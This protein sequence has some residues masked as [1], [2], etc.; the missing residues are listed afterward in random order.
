MPDNTTLNTGTGGDVIATDEVT[1]LNGSA[2]SGVKV[3]RVKVMFGAD[4]A[5]TDASADSPLP[6]KASNFAATFREPFQSFPGSN[7][8]S[9]NTVSGDVVR[10][11]GNA[12]GASYLTISKNPLDASGGDTVIETV[13]NFGMPLEV[14]AGIHLSQRINGQEFSLELTSNET[15]DTAPAEL[16][17]SSISQATTT[18]TV[19]TSASHG[20]VVGQRIGIYG[21]SDSRMN[22][23]TLVVATTPSETQFTCTAGPQGALPSVTAGPF[24][25]GFVYS[26]SAMDRRPNGTS[27]IFENAT[28]TNASFYTKSENGDPMPI[29]GTLAGSHAVTIASTASVQSIN[30]TANYAFRPTSEYRLVQ[31]ADRVQWHDVAIDAV[32]QSTARAT[33]TQVIP[34]NAINYKVRFRARN[35]KGLTVPNAKIVSATKTGTTTA[36]IVTAAAHGLTTGDVVNIYGIRDQAAASFPNLTA[37]TAVASVVDA[38][39]FT[40][41]IGTAS[42]VT[43]YGGYVSRVQG[44]QVQ[45]GAITQAVQS[46]QITSSRLTLV[47]SANWT[48]LSIGDFVNLHGCRDNS[49]GADLTIDGAFRVRD[50]ATTNLVLEPLPGTTIPT[51]LALT[52]CGGGIIKRTDMR[53]SFVRVF[54][55]DRLRIETL[56]R[57]TGDAAGAAPTVVQGGTIAISSGTVTT[58]TTLST[59]T[60]GGAAEDA[61][62]GAN[63]VTVGG[64]V[65]T[66][67]TPTTLVAGD[68]IR[69]TFGATGA[70]VVKPYAVTEAEWNYTG[71]LTTT[72]AVPAVAAAGAS[73]RR[74]ITGIQAINTGASA[75]DLIILDGAVERW[76][77]TLPPN[78]PIDPQFVNALTA[79]AN[80]ALNLNLSAAGT[81][82][83]NAQG[84]TA[85]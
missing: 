34:N 59:L 74:Y 15:Q 49:T 65:R 26:R 36:T 83:V 1:T 5:A 64:V 45:G 47:G 28:A 6:V 35:N 72:T 8:T 46:A 16:A 61:A 55:F 56:A 79:T 82:R 81:V 75:V 19:T 80:T 14:A 42:T 60:G 17:I 84:Y 43:S 39:T 10:V 27:M 2:S 32:A 22:Y 62:A 63:P 52:N 20:L 67:T 58:V 18:L 73:L 48:G 25:S 53:I 7:W 24:T 50:I 78:V 13:R 23:A 9:V 40:I 29:G 41:V 70:A 12:G 69:F 57:P 68:A 38:T 51:T 71:Q 30:S 4:G 37:A 54:D 66:A 76:R 3:Q 77:M 44:G 33:V 21:C 31:M 11:E 85:P